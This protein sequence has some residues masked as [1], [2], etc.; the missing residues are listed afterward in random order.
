MEFLN[1][2]MLDELSEIN[3]TA[4]RITFLPLFSFRHSQLFILVG[5]LLIKCQ[6]YNCRRLRRATRYWVPVPTSAFSGSGLNI[7]GITVSN[8]FSAS[9]LKLPPTG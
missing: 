4:S 3:L 2:Q 5:I 1:L 7:R 6:H 8:H 9:E